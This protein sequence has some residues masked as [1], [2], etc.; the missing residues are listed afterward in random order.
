MQAVAHGGIK[1]PGLSPDK[2]KEFVSENKDKKGYKKL[3]EKTESFSRL[4]KYVKE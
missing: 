4:K 1:K 2:A 3:P